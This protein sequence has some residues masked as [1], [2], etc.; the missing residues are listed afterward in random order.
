MQKYFVTGIGTE[1]GKTV[2]SAVLVEKLKADYWK[3]I[4]SGDLQHSDSMKI[5]QWISNTKTKIH[6]E[7]FRLNHPLSPHLSAEMDGIS[8]Q[9]TDFQIPNTRNSLIIEGAGGIYVPI[10]NHETILDLIQKLN[11]ETIIVSKHYLGSI[12]HTILTIETL[13]HKG[14]SIKG[15]IFNGEQNKASE[16]FILENGKIPLIGHIPLMDNIDQNQ[17]AKAG[18]HLKI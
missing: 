17:I 13:K 15:I 3:P 16:K 9:L 11:F 18:L 5:Q 2:T 7:Q 14:I 10:N 8:M 4:Q 6:P 12:N 1:I